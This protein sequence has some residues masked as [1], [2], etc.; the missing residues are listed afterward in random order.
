LAGKLNRDLFMK[1]GVRWLSGLAFALAVMS[2]AIERPAAQAV[3]FSDVEDLPLMSGLR[4]IVDEGMVFD[5]PEGRI[6]EAIA[7]GTVSGEAIAAFYNATL[8]ELGWEQIGSDTFSRSGE[9]LQ[10]RLGVVEG[11]TSVRFSIAPN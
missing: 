10:Y 11:E 1:N 4:E 5:K 3:F 9:V 6:V 2:I 7:I 8:P